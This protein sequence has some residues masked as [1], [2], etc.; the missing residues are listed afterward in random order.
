MS[1]ISWAETLPSSIS[2]GGDVERDWLSMMTSVAL[3]LKTSFA[4]PGSG[5][6]SL[7]SAGVSLFGNARMARAGNSAVTGQYNDGFLLLNQNHLSVHHIGST[8]TG[9]VGHSA[10]VDHGGGLGNAP[11]ASRWLTQSSNTTI[12]SATSFGTVSVTFPVPYG[13]NPFLLLNPLQGNAYFVNISSLSTGGFSA[14][15]S[16]VVTQVAALGAVTLAWESDG[17][18]AR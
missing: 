7:T 12:P 3:G 2:T 4:W 17:T 16:S 18:V 8:W 10:M 15:F 5:G 13:A 1:A 6:G 14:A 11:F 9:M